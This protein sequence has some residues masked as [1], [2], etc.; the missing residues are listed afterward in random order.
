V[1]APDHICILPAADLV[2]P[3][4]NGSPASSGSTSPPP[5]FLCGGALGQYL[6][7]P[8]RGS[9]IAPQIS[10][11]RTWRRSRSIGGTRRHG[12]SAQRSRDGGTCSGCSSRRPNWSATLRFTFGWRGRCGPAPERCSVTRPTPPRDAQSALSISLWVEGLVRRP[13]L[14]GCCVDNLFL[15]PSSLVPPAA[16]DDSGSQ[17]ID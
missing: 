10:R 3:K 16:Q 11:T 4:R 2:Q 17:P 9:P 13:R 14:H 8:A 12:V 1:R 7:Q 5:F 15:P 6:S